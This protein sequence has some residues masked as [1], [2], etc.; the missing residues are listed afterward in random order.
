MSRIVCLNINNDKCSLIIEAS[1]LGC[2]DRITLNPTQLIEFKNLK[3]QLE[4]QNKKSQDFDLQT[5]IITKFRNL[6]KLQK[7][8]QGHAYAECENATDCG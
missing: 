5:K 4:A 1:G 7:D 8:G 6:E 3:A 2:V